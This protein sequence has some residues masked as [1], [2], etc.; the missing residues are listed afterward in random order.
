MQDLELE[1]HNLF[2]KRRGLRS[3]T[4]QL[5]REL[6]HAPKKQQEITDF[7][8]DGNEKNA[9]RFLS[10][11]EENEYIT[12]VYEERVKVVKAYIGK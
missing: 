5:L 11:L 3:I 1:L 4:V 12:R 10:V 9:S 7:Y 6:A 8:F 2:P